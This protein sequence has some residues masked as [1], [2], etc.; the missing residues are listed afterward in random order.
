MKKH[1]Q[2]REQQSRKQHYFSSSL[3]TKPTLSSP[4][5]GQ[6]FM[7]ALS[8]NDIWNPLHKVS[9]KQKPQYKASHTVT[10]NVDEFYKTL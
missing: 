7:G 3:A 9:G 1:L 5:R 2:K 4:K 6:M 8:L 10:N